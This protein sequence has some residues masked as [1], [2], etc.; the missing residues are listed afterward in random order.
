[1]AGPEQ[2]LFEVQNRAAGIPQASRK[3]MMELE[4]FDFQLKI[5]D[6]QLN[7]DFQLHLLGLSEGACPQCPALCALACW[8]GGGAADGDRNAEPS[9]AN[10]SR[11]HH[12]VTMV[13]NLRS[14]TLQSEK[15][16]R[17]HSN[18]RAAPFKFSEP[19]HQSFPLFLFSE[20]FPRRK[21]R[22][23]KSGCAVTLRAMTR[24]PRR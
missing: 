18:T 11:A 9:G 7:V 5:V 12:R 19:F 1:L 17:L 24:R 8:T 22:A 6:F 4:P 3:L 21:A 13:D 10:K 16:S 23:S 2:D 20:P 15:K 14:T